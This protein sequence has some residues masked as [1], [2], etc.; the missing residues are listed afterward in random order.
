MEA[1]SDT[2]AST[3]LSFLLAMI[4]HPGEYKKAQIEVDQVCGALRSPTSDDIDR[5][6][7]LKACMDEVSDTY[8]TRFRAMLLKL[9]NF[10][11]RRSDGA[12]SP[13]VV[14]LTC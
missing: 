7:F 14:F 3:L 1:G 4:K 12:P 5:L 11:S 6:P 9:T 2:S 10:P 8:I 13:L